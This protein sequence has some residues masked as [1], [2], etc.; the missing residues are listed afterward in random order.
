MQK[1]NAYLNKV[2]VMLILYPLLHLAIS[3][4]FILLIRTIFFCNVIHAEELTPKI[5]E[6]PKENTRSYTTFFG[7]AAVTGI[8][9]YAD[10]S[11]YVKDSTASGLQMQALLLLESDTKNKALRQY[12]KEKQKDNSAEYEDLLNQE[13]LENRNYKKLPEGKIN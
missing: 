7:I 2:N 3:I 1:V 12:L 8:T 10:S 6:V 11:S 4:I 9:T 13:F 5:E